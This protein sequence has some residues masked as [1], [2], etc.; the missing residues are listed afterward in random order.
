MSEPAATDD[1][2]A[3]LAAGTEPYVLAVIWATVDTERV[4]AG[5]GLPASS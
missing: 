5:I 3:L 4:L 1:V 2:E